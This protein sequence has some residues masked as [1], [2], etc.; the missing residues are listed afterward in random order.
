LYEL[1]EVCDV[2]LTSPARRDNLD[3]QDIFSSHLIRI[4]DELKR[5][6]KRVDPLVAELIGVKSDIWRAKIQRFDA[7]D[8]DA[9][10]TQAQSELW[11]IRNRLSDADLELSRLRREVEALAA[12]R[13]MALNEVQRLRN[14]FSATYSRTVQEEETSL[15][16]ELKNKVAFLK[17]ELGKFYVLL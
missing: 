1:L 15:R 4:T 9:L 11:R 7:Q 16:E 6:P 2:E 3:A 12:D 5:V 17:S 14:L 13:D 10:E 8:S